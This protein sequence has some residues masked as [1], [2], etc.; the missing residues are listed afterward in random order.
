MEDVT[1]YLQYNIV[2]S[3]YAQVNELSSALIYDHE[4]R[5]KQHVQSK[6][7]DQDDFH[8]AN[9]HL[10]KKDPRFAQSDVSASPKVLDGAS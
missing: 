5:R 1:A 6:P 9:F 4:F 7:W 3:D 2:F 10:C 8:L